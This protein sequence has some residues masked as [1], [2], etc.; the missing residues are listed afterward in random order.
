M[1]RLSFVKASS[2]FHGNNKK[3]KRAQKAGCFVMLYANLLGK[4]RASQPVTSSDK[5]LF[6]HISVE[7]ICQSTSRTQR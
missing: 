5:E 7:T 4:I 1:N 2:G 3:R 6:R